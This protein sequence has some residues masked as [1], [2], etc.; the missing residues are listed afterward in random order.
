MELQY[1]NIKNKSKEK[2]ETEFTYLAEEITDLRHK[3]EVGE[4]AERVL[5]EKETRVTELMKDRKSVV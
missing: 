4:W 1:E 5:Q 2:I 3:I